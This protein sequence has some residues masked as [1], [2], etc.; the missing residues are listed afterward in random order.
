VQAKNLRL[1]AQL[2]EVKQKHS[3]AV[4]QVEASSS[5]AAQNQALMEENINLKAEN[6][7]LKGQVLSLTQELENATKELSIL[8]KQFQ[9][10]VL[11][12]NTK[13]RQKKASAD[14]A[15]MKSPH[16]KLAKGEHTALTLARIHVPQAATVVA[17]K[18]SPFSLS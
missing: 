16:T 14:L 12:H 18:H 9:K 7:E 15:N 17:L 8:Q 6:E 3:L 10:L 5:T 4:A 1:A 13:G 11:S 2:E